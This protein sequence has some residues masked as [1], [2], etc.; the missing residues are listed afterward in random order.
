MQYF[1]DESK[2]VEDYT[3]E[4]LKEAFGKV[5]SYKREI[6]FTH[7]LSQPIGPKECSVVEKQTAYF[8]SPKKF[9]IRGLTCNSGFTFSDA[10]N[11]MTITI[12]EQNYDK[13]KNK[14]SLSLQTFFRVNFVK[15]VMFFEKKIRTEANKE[16]T[17]CY[18]D[19]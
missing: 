15:S 3:P 19:H 9:I 6:K 14:L 11:P 13:K 5:N 4:E 17:M 1:A 2:T 18:K 10:F 12:V 16:T 7:P 8:I